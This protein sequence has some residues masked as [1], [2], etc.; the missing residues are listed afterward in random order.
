TPE[1]KSRVS[2]QLVLDYVQGKGHPAGLPDFK[3]VKKGLEESFFGGIYKLVY[4]PQAQAKKR[5]FEHYH[6]MNFTHNPNA[7]VLLAMLREKAGLRMGLEHIVSEEGRIDVHAEEDGL[8]YK[9]GWT[10][11]KHLVYSRKDLE[12]RFGKPPL[13]KRFK[14][15]FNV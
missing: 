13:Q 10:G 9:D 5:S 1:E 6:V 3:L 14:T 2:N 12:K 8:Y 7:T 11:M 4:S 15:L